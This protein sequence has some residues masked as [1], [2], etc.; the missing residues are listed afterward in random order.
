MGIEKGGATMFKDRLKSNRERLGLTQF[1]LAERIHFSR[2]A[3]AKWEQG[4]GIPAKETLTVLCEVFG[5]SESELYEFD[6]AGKA[7]EAVQRMSHRKTWVILALTA[8]SL[9]AAGV[10]VW[11]VLLRNAP[12][13][14]RLVISKT[15]D[16]IDKAKLERA[17][18]PDLPMPALDEASSQYLIEQTSRDVWKTGHIGAEAFVQYRLEVLSYLQNNPYISS[19]SAVIEHPEEGWRN[20]ETGMATFS[21]NTFLL[22]IS[23]T[24]FPAENNITIS[25]VSGLNPSREAFSSVPYHT[26]TL[27]YFPEDVCLYSVD[28]EQLIGNFILR[29][30]DYGQ[31]Q[32]YETYREYHSKNGE[33]CTVSFTAGK[34][35]LCNEWYSIERISITNEN[36]NEYAA[37]GVMGGYLSVQSTE[38]YSPYYR[39]LGNVDYHYFVNGER[40][41]GTSSLNLN[42]QWPFFSTTIVLGSKEVKITIDSYSIKGGYFYVL[43]RKDGAPDPYPDRI[44]YDDS[45]LA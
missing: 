42:N 25:Y 45:G 39:F 32:G 29:L 20:E 9:A 13:P 35:F 40:K 7:V 12:T 15:S 36:I 14:E 24:D 3:V 4:R 23:L 30:R 41:D 16:G 5:I 19:L 43:K 18:L 33:A 31:R 34:Q 17:A 2:S 1:E 10:A 38:P 11:A 27:I 21:Q 26:I 28:G 8:F 22:P 37:I 44:A 6:D